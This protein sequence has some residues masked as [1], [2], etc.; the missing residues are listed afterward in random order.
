MLFTEVNFNFFDV[1][2]KDSKLEIEIWKQKTGTRIW[3][4]ELRLRW[5]KIQKF[6]FNIKSN[7]NFTQI[8][9]ALRPY[10]GKIVFLSFQNLFYFHIDV[11]LVAIHWRYYIGFEMYAFFTEVNFISLVVWSKDS[12]LLNCFQAK[13]WGPVS[14]MQRMIYTFHGVLWNWL[15]YWQ[16]VQVYDVAKFGIL[17]DDIASCT[18]LYTL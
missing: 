7:D 10:L 14:I 8:G 3:V 17:T 6:K 16:P 11:L 4:P 12:F 15:M 9:P 13:I 2:S 1:W 18:I 5:D